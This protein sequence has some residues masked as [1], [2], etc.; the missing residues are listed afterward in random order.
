M[1]PDI[2]L[3]SGSH[4]LPD[5]AEGASFSKSCVYIETL[6][7]YWRSR[8]W[9]VTVRTDHDPDDDV[10]FMARSAHFLVKP[11]PVPE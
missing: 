5:D 7:S 1:P 2:V 6:A 4:L 9:R 8:G 3:V 10:V 11:F